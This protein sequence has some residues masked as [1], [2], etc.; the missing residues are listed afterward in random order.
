MYCQSCFGWKDFSSM[1]EAVGAGDA[2]HEGCT[3]R[4]R[5]CGLAAGSA[6]STPARED[7]YALRVA[8]GRCLSTCRC[9]NEIA[10][11]AASVLLKQICVSTSSPSAGIPWAASRF[12]ERPKRLQSA[13]HCTSAGV[14]V[15]PPGEFL[16]SKRPKHPSTPPKYIKTLYFS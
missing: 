1:L 7:Q 11:L 14:R 10:L 4:P 6:P 2:Q 8:P 16:G 12:A 3:A 5:E 13:S 15:T 9:R